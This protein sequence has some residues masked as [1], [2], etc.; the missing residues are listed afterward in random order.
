MEVIQNENL[1]NQWEH[2]ALIEIVEHLI[3]H[4]HESARKDLIVL[5]ELAKKVENAHAHHARCPKGLSDYLNSFA[6][7]LQ[8]HLLKEEEILFPLIKNGQGKLAYMPIKVM[9]EEHDEHFDTLKH[10]RTLTFNYQLPKDAC[11][12]WKMLYS[13][14]QKFEE[15]MNEH[16]Y[17][18]DQILF[19]KALMP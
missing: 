12:A 10:F 8:E 5:I 3:S 18:E 17:L 13:K 9:Q 19:V 16:I 4:Y 7:D 11:G 2:K 1:K 6:A 14:L 15:E